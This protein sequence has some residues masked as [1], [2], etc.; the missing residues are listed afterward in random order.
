MLRFE[1]MAAQLAPLVN[2]ITPHFPPSINEA[3][4]YEKILK[5]RDEV[6]AGTHPRLTVP[7]HALQNVTQQTQP[8]LTA[9]ANLAVPPTL[10]ASRSPFQP[11]NDIQPSPILFPTNNHGL[12]ALAAASYPP[13]DPADLSFATEI[14]QDAEKR[15]QLRKTLEAALKKQFEQKK[16]DA[17]RVP[18][19]PECKPDFDISALLEKVLKDTEAKDDASSDS[20]DENS[21]YSSRAPDSTP[22]RGAPS[23]SPQ[24]DEEGYTAD[25]P[26]GARVSAVMGAPLD[27]DADKDR[28]PRYVP[29]EADA[30]EVDDEEEEG[31]YSPPEAVDGEVPSDQNGTM[32]DGRDPRSRHLRRYSDAYDGGRRPGSPDARMVRIFQHFPPRSIL[33]PVAAC[34]KSSPSQNQRGRRQ[35]QQAGSPEPIQTRKKRKLGKQE[36]RKRP[37]SPNSF[38]KSENVSPPPFNDVPELGGGRLPPSNADRPIFIDDNAPREVRYVSANDRYMDQTGRPISRHPDPPMPLSEP[39]VMSRASMRPLRDDQDL[40]RVASMQSMRMEQPREYADPVYETPTRRVAS[41][42]ASSP[43]VSERPRFADEYDRP[44]QEVR[45]SGTPGPVYRQAYRE[46][47]QVR[48]ELMPPPRQERIVVDEH[49]NRYREV[50]V[51]EDRE[52]APTRA[53]SVRPNDYDSPR[54]EQYRTFRSGSV[55]V[56]SPPERRYAQDMPPPPPM[57][58][59]SEAPRSSVAAPLDRSTSVQVLDRQPRQ[60]VYV[61]EREYREPIRMASARPQ[62]EEMPRESMARASSV[63]PVTVDDRLQPRREHLPAEQPRYRVVEPG[64]RYYDSQGREV[65]PQGSVQRY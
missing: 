12:A 23:P 62:Y 10:P 7:A 32:Y 52:P 57:Y 60:P 36:R 2:G 21:F 63:R 44:V 11:R 39:R 19:P 25:A 61:D 27:G 65:I 18:A 1:N 6:F 53:A 41:Y 33:H 15:S 40:R 26:S 31:E 45:V 34:T 64:E 9:Q 56:D 13:I 54:H 30:M 20:F 50:V 59:Q 42:R 51:P 47:P 14:P 17:R 48:Y 35:R 5:L 49:G 38:V 3:L 8:T 58:R 16:E 24:Q 37:L 29:R 4:E 22:E 43:V 28:S 46:E 55:Y